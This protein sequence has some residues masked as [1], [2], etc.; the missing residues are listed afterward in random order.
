MQLIAAVVGASAWEAH[1][2]YLTTAHFWYNGEFLRATSHEQRTTAFPQTQTD[3]DASGKPQRVA[4]RLVQD[5]PY[6]LRWGR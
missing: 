2:R 3:N 5:V 6:E 1:Q 4:G